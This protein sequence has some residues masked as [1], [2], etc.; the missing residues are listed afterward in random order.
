M[1]LGMA[2]TM[3]V[4]MVGWMAYRGHGRRA[5]HGDDGRDAPPGL[6]R[7]RPPV[8]GA[9]HGPRHPARDRA[10]RD[11]GEHA[12]RRCCCVAPSTRTERTADVAS[13]RW[14]HERRSPSSP[15]SR[16]CSRSSSARPRSPAAASTSDPGSPKREQTAMGRRGHGGEEMRR[17]GRP[18][19]RRQR[20]RAD[21]RARADRRDAGQALRP[22]LPHRRPPRADRARLRRRAHQAHA[23][24][25]RPARH[26]RLPAPAPDPERGRHLVGPA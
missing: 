25:R 5:E 24:D 9:G 7:R 10:C 15:A 19:P 4:P 8:G 6:R 20:R 12:R 3:T 14:R 1:L 23:P 26:D 18:R 21:A 22:R 13:R 2:V 11:A 17:A 16:S